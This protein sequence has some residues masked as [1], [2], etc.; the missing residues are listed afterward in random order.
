MTAVLKN[1]SSKYESIAKLYTIGKSVQGREL[2]VMEISDL[3]GKHERGEPEFKYVGNM[4]GNEVVSREILLL[5]I[6]HL[7]E[8]YGKDKDITKVIDS[9]RIHI[10]PSMN[11]DG[12]ERAVEGVCSGVT[13]R[14]NAKGIDLNRYCDIFFFINSAFKST[15]CLRYK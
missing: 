10:M 13:G 14:A 4:H 12:Y 1:L 8:S 7:L 9:T 6:Q 15:I 3:P 2:W 11:P 5:L